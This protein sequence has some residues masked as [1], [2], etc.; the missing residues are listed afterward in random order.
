VLRNTHPQVRTLARRTA[1]KARLSDCSR[2]PERGPKPMRLCAPCRRRAGDRNHGDGATAWTLEEAGRRFGR[3]GD[4]Q[5]M[6]PRS[7]SR[8]LGWVGGVVDKGSRSRPVLVGGHSHHR[9]APQPELAALTLA[10]Q[11]HYHGTGED[12]HNRNDSTCQG[13]AQPRN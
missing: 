1:V 11:K 12:R 9:M 3:R 2:L 7:D 13:S 10:V 6:R 4:G 5:G 8:L